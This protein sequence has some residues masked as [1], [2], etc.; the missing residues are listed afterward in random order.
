M[1]FLFNTLISSALPI[2]NSCTLVSSQYN[3]GDFL[4][5]N[6]NNKCDTCISHSNCSNM[7]YCRYSSNYGHNICSYEPITNKWSLGMTIGVIIIL[8]ANL[9]VAGVGVGGGAVY[10]PILMIICQY[11]PAYAVPASTA[12]IFGGT[13]ATTLFNLNKKHRKYDRPLINYNVTALMQPTTWLA[14]IIGVIFNSIIPKWLQY[15]LQSI[16]ALLTAYFTFQKGR[17]ADRKAKEDKMKN[18]E[19]EKENIETKK[20]DQ[21]DVETEEKSYSVLVMWIVFIIWF[22]FLLFIFIRGGRKTESIIGIKFCSTNYWISTFLPYP[23]L[24][25]LCWWIYTIVKNYPILGEKA[26]VDSSQAISLM[27]VGFIVGLMAGLLGIGGGII[28]GPILLMFGVDPEE[29]SATSSFMIFLT[30][31]STVIQYIILGI[32]SFT[33]FS[34]YFIVAFITFLMGMYLLRWLI[35]KIGSRSIILYILAIVVFISGIL[36]VYQGSVDTIDSIKKD[37]PMGFRSFFN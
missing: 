35:S 14:T 18:N 21:F 37:A 17:A 7:F 16:L 33:D 15:S 19:K 27:G 12:L 20:D 6:L 23:I 36:M 1:I 24:L 32:L 22:V 8:I 10:V 13:L 2:N 29:M 3:C 34:I 26:D 9:L 31:S 11:P 4:Y 25:G 28:I 30:A 5:C